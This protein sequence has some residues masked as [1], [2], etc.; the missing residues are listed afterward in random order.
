MNKMVQSV[1]HVNLLLDDSKKAKPTSDPA[2]FLYD[3]NGQ[4]KYLTVSERRLWLG[5]VKTMPTRPRLF[6]ETLA[7]SGAR[8]S[9]VLALLPTSFDESEG[10]VIIECLKKRRRGVFRALPLPHSLISE[11]KALTT[12]A[13]STLPPDQ[14][15]WN[16][17]RTTAWKLVKQAM[18]TARLT[19]PKASPKGL[20]HSFGVNSLPSCPIT[21][22]KKWLGHSRLSTTEIYAGAV[23]REERAIATKIWKGF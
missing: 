14:R 22:V 8:V 12:P 17:S 18:I 23:G 11:I 19:G 5:A 1:N 6:L 3:R 7:Y 15:I 4:R 20:R 13:G 2:S 10:V 21:L 16:W 9:E